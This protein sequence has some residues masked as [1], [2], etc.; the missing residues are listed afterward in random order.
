MK[1][2]KLIALTMVVAI[3]LMG[4][5]YAAWTDS[6]QVNASIQTGS[7][8]VMVR[9]A[10]AHNIGGSQGIADISSD[11][12]SISFTTTGLYPAAYKSG[13]KNTYGN[14][15]FSIENQGS[16]PVKLDK[17]VFDP[18]ET[19]SD[20]WKYTRAKIFIHKGN[21]AGVNGTTL[22]NSVA[23]HK[24]SSGSITGD[25]KDL[26]KLIIEGSK[27]SEIT[28]MPGECIW[29]EICDY[30]PLNSPNETQNQQISFDLKFDWKQANQ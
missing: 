15:H 29:F 5:G 27:L 25:L 21:P 3:I 11:K 18:K 16:I 30:L 1:K 6:T 10:N 19:G 8:D 9:W 12:N 13:D 28:F 26:G 24:D 4:A 2:T 20:A 23:L 7:M 22:K 17:I 14:M